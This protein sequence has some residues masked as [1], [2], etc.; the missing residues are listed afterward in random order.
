M[1]NQIKMNNNKETCKTFF[2]FSLN[3]NVT[4]VS[5]FS[6]PES[7]GRREALGTSLLKH[8]LLEL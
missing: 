1:G 5:L 8:I 6:V 3:T 7:E 2:C 4:R